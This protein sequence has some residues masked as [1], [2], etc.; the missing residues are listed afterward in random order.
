MN[1]EAVIK[2][3]AKRIKHKSADST[4]K[5]KD[6]LAL[7]VGNVIDVL[8]DGEKLVYLLPSGDV[9]E[10]VEVDGVTYTPPSKADIQYLLPDKDRVLKLISDTYDTCDADLY[11]RLLEYHKLISDLPDELFYD[12]FVL[13]DFHTYLQ[14]L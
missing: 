2:A 1:D 5:Q 13:W 8:D 7:D 12:L 6:K 11:I 14:K 4:D 3:A 9:V 10:K